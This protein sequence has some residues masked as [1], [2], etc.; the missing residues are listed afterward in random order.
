MRLTQPRV[1]PVDLNDEDTPTDTIEFLQ[2]FARDDGRGIDGQLNIFKTLAHHPDLL[3]RW[4]VFG[5]HILFKSSLPARDRELAIL[6]V[7]WRCR[8]GYEWGQHCV[9]G[10]REGITDEEIRRI[11]DGPNAEGWTQRE[12][13]LLRAADE[14]H[15]DSFV[16]DS[17]W[18]T[19][20]QHYDTRQLIDLI[21]TIG[22]YHL[23]S[24]A[25]NTFG[26]QL[27]PGVPT[28]EETAGRVPK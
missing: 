3:R 9:I 27:D 10:K 26:V 14:L 6:R 22:Q 20:Q 2:K 12:A 17:T 7:G 18:G 19:L 1:D 21:F 23:V 4:T 8:S 25:L 11:A 16:S 24:M 5:N 28:F 15:D 13:A